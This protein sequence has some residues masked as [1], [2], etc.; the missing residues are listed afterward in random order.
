MKNLKIKNADEIKETMALQEEFVWNSDS[1]HDLLCRELTY[2][3]QD[4]YS[5]LAKDGALNNIY[6]LG[7]S[8]LSNVSRG[9]SDNETRYIICIG[10]HIFYRYEVIDSIGE[11]SYSNVLKCMDHKYQKIVALKITK[12]AKKYKKS[13]EDEVN[14]LSKLLYSVNNYKYITRSASPLIANINKRF[15]WRKHPVISMDLYG[16]NLYSAHL[17]NVSYNNGKI[18]II[19]I[20][21]ALNF[22]KENDIVHCDLKPENIFFLNNDPSNFNVLIS[23]FGLSKYMSELKKESKIHYYTQTRWYR[24]PEVILHIPFDFSIDMW[25]AAAIILEL[26]FEY[27]IFQSKEWYHNLIIAEHIV[28][29]KIEISELNTDDHR[30]YESKTVKILDQYKKEKLKLL[31]NYKVMR[32]INRVLTSIEHFPYEDIKELVNKIFIWDH[33]KRVTPIEALKIFT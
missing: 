33:S 6:Y 3:E 20:L 15:Y 28:K 19:D 23:D 7:N 24:S 11:G 18:I 13:F 10:D 27:A 25:S 16:K 4:E 8:Y 31:K 1:E 2:Y 26:F 29:S 5:H 14:I 9:I 32:H 22:L 17:K 30:F 12:N 21:E